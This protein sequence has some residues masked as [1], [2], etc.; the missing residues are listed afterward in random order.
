[1][2]ARQSINGYESR[3]REYT[4]FAVRGIKKVCKECGPRPPCSPQ[5]KKAQEM[6][7][8]ELETCCDDVRMEPFRTAPRAFMGWVRLSMAAGFLSALAYNL[9]YAL[10]GAALLALMVLIMLLEFGMYK[11][12]LDVFMPK[13]ESQNVVGVRKPAGEVKRRIILGGHADSANEWWYTYL[14]Y[15]WFKKPVLMLPVIG[16]ALISMLFSL[17]VYIAAAVAGKGLVGIGGLAQYSSAQATLGYVCA[18]LCLLLV[19]C[20]FFELTKLPV[21]GANDNLSGCFT[22][23]A[24]AK[25]MADN[26]IRLENTELVV[27]CAGCE[28]AGLRGAKAFSKAHTAEYGDVETAFIALDTMTDMEFIKVMC[29]DLN[30]TVKHDPAVCAMLKAGAKTAGHDIPYGS[31]FFGSSDATAA[32]QAGMRACLLS[33]MDE[34]PA[35]YYHTRLD[36]TDRLQPKTVEACLDILMETVYQFDETGLAPFEGAQVKVEKEK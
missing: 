21:E 8:K 25:L 14:G 17:G 20:W 13:K 16:A 15:K 23:M 18:G 6:M 9:G 24:V 36:T 10:V 31:V 12:A 34:A 4:N 32:T 5:E 22:A 11:Q 19:P 35:D 3:L 33:A 29:R 26:D 28:E 30:G 1:M 27:V 2:T 7:K